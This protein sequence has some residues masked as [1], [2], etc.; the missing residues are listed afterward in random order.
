VKSNSSGVS[1][2]SCPEFRGSLSD[3]YRRRRRTLLSSFSDTE[4]Q[5][6]FDLRE[7]PPAPEGPDGTREFSRRLWF[8]AADPLPDDP[9][10]HASAIAFASDLGVTIAASVTAGLYRRASVLTS[11]DHA[12]WWHRPCG[13]TRGRCSTW[14]GSN[15]HQRGTVRGTV[16]TADGSLA[17]SLG[18][19]TLIR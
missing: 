11:L 18:Q 9:A 13:P 16:H 1:Y 3:G 4:H 17:A 5:S 15:S 14:S 10:V 2:A 8:R 6:V 12:L 7:L 19:D